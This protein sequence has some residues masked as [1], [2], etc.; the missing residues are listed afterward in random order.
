M[1]AELDSLLRKPQACPLYVLWGL[2]FF[3]SLQFKFAQHITCIDKRLKVFELVCIHQYDINLIFV[4]L[5]ISSFC[6]AND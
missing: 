2:I 5:N 6:T 1:G 4:H 3:Y